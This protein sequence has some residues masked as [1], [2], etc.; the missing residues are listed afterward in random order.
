MEPE[1]SSPPLPPRSVALMRRSVAAHGQGNLDRAEAGYRE[2]TER[3]PG[4]ADAW[5][6]LG[7]LRHQRGDGQEALPPLRRARELDPDNLAFLLNFGRVL[8][9]QGKLEDSLAC[10]R[11]AH[12]MHP[13]DPATLVG[14]SE[15]LL[16]LQRGGEL[17][18]EIRDRLAE[19]GGAWH[20]WSLLGQCLEQSGDR[21]EALKAFRKA[22][23]TAPADEAGPHLQLA[24]CA[25]KG[26][27]YEL[28]RHELEQALK[29]APDAASACYG[30]A[31]LASLEGDFARSEQ[32]ARRALE[33][34]PTYYPAWSLIGAVRE[35]DIDRD[36]AEELEQAANRAGRDIQAWPLHMARGK[37]WERMQEYDRAFSAYDAA[38]EALARLR[39]YEPEMHETYVRNLTRHLGGEFL[40]RHQA[41]SR[42]DRGS[43]PR[44]IFVCGMPRSGTT[45]VE[46]ILAS[47]PQVQAGGEMRFLHDRLKRTLGNV[48]LID[49]GKWLG[50]I[51]TPHLVELA[52][53]WD[54][55]LAEAAGGRPCVT[56]KMP[57]NYNLL[58]LIHACF[59]E[60]PIVYVGRDA[61][62]TCFSCFAT[63]F[64][65]GHHFSYAQTAIAH[66]YHL[67]ERM[68]EHW[69]EVLGPD[70]ITVIS[71]EDL[72]RDPEP[73]VRRLLEA[74]GLAWDPGC[75]EFHK[76]RRTVMT[77]SVY[78]VRQPMY[79]SSI[80]RWRHFEHH[81]SPL[82]QGLDADSVR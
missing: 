59:P 66:H 47:H 82:L 29:I 33:L 22:V 76:T 27:Q 60:A 30:L 10:L 32:L 19:D 35:R 20:L 63:S 57:S 7:L 23:E 13:D 78:Q 37:A 58:G 36:F 6:F 43:A 71:Y 8:R 48:G 72:V 50:Q 62:D 80:G 1:I 70:R 40:D 41:V 21:A 75:L 77:A 68:L 53:D 79:D 42:R 65:E 9:E 26:M 39:P 15:T 18:P 3:H 54:R 56:D 49:T 38:N 61:R 45:L 69:R 12:E 34:D 52:G 55:A 5:H 4:F 25:T 16:A 28:A 17:I 44:P 74:V 14:L 11:Y 51:S 46:T 2:L 31:D 67:H 73:R 24:G 64:A 81:L